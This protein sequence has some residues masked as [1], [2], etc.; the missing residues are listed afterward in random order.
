MHWRLLATMDDDRFPL[1]STARGSTIAD[2]M[3]TVRPMGQ[4]EN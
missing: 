3:R 1:E 4:G 2:V